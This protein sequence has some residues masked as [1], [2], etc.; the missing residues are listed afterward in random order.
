MYLVSRCLKSAS[1]AASALDAE[2]DADGFGCVGGDG[3]CCAA[4]A[5]ESSKHSN[6]GMEMYLTC[7]MLLLPVHLKSTIRAVSD[8][9]A[10]GEVKKPLKTAD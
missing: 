8:P 3:F 1:V 7:R 4:P 2:G 9:Y 10:R 6:I 5:P